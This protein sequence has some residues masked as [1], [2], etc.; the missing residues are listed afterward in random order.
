[1][2]CS[3]AITFEQYSSDMT[4]G[5][6]LAFL[7]VIGG[8]VRENQWHLYRYVLSHIALPPDVPFSYILLSCHTQWLI[9]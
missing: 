4:K 7:E 1:M 2:K 8:G 9:I 6:A 5:N 3:K